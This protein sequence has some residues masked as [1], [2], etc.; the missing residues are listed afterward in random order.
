MHLTEFAKKL[1]VF[2]IVVIVFLALDLFIKELAATNLKEE[3]V[4]IPGF[5]S[6]QLTYNDDMGFSLLRFADSFLDKTSKIM[7]IVTLQFIGVIIAAYFYF[8]KTEFLKPWPKKLPLALICAGGLGNAIDRILRGRVVDYILW[9]VKDFSWP[10]FNLA[11]TYTV[12]GLLTLLILFL[13]TERKK[14]VLSY[15]TNI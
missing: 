9:Y 3:I 11:D 2:V 5:W 10:I 12:I 6:F 8:T 1:I 7:V 4:V 14:K 15:K 13:F